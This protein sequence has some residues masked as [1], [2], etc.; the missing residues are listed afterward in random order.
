MVKYR[1]IQ[2]FKGLVKNMNTVEIKR[3]LSDPGRIYKV[4]NLSGA[5]RAHLDELRLM[6]SLLQDVASGKYR[7]LPKNTVFSIA[8]VITYILLPSDALPDI[9]PALGL[10]D[11]LMVYR[12]AMKF[13]RKD[14]DDYKL[15]L[16]VPQPINH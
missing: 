5:F 11:D 6:L 1:A 15:W 13:I 10:L 12:Y 4:V 2:L 3:L 14:L 16:S 7:V 9:I 8:G